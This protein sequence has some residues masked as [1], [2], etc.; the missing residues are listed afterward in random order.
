MIDLKGFFR[1][2]R[3]RCF[4]RAVIQSSAMGLGGIRNFT[5]LI[6]FEKKMT[7]SLNFE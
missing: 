2:K 6:I 3:V 7:F 4:G 5:H 1:I